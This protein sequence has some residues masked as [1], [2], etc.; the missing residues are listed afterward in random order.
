MN[1]DIL[2]DMY[3]TMDET[4]QIQDGDILWLKIFTSMDG[5]QIKYLDNVYK[6]YTVGNPD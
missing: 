4:H 6:E 5:Q 1:S 3:V 2:R